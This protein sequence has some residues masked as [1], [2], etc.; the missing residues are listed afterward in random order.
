MNSR[1]RRV[2]ANLSQIQIRVR[3][4][5]RWRMHMGGLFAVIKNNGGMKAL[6]SFKSLW[7]ALFL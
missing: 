6:E 7:Q 1:D 2:V 3:N 5:T 4:L